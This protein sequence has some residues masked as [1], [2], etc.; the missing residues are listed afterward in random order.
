MSKWTA[1][2][3]KATDQ[4]PK[5]RSKRDTYLICQEYITVLNSSMLLSAELELFGPQMAPF[6]P[7]YSPFPA[8][9]NFW[10]SALKMAYISTRLSRPRFHLWQRPRTKLCS[11]FAFLTLS[12]SRW[13]SEMPG[14]FFSKRKIISVSFF[15]M[16]F[17]L[18]LQI[19]ILLNSYWLIHIKGLVQFLIYCRH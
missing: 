3:F 12:G 15:L 2:T 8:S 5:E 14:F 17:K 1:Y 10:R 16:H 19:V 7:D 18:R 6:W 9:L 4:S 11:P 13:R